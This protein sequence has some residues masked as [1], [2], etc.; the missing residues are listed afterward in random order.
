M[1]LEI[2]GNMGESEVKSFSCPSAKAKSGALLLGVRQDDGT[3]AI[4][5]TPLTVDEHFLEAVALDEMAPEQRFRFTNKC[6]EGGCNQW[7][8]SYCGVIERVIKHMNEM[9]LLEEAPACGIR[10]SCRWFAQRS[11]DACKVCPLIIT[12]ITEEQREEMMQQ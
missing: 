2:L 6:I 10:N 5:P 12:E 3:V 11:F 1:R 7:T 8:G 9:P 4:L